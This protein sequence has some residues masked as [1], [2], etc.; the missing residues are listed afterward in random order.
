MSRVVDVFKSPTPDEIF[1]SW[2]NSLSDSKIR[3]Y[4]IEKGTRI[5]RSRISPAENID[6]VEKIIFGLIFF[7]LKVSPKYEEKTIKISNIKRIE[8]YDY[9]TITPVPIFSS[10]KQIPCKSCSGSGFKTCKHCDGLG[11]IKCTACKGT[12]KLNCPDCDGHGKI[13]ITVKVRVNKEKT[14]KRK[15]PVACPRCHGSGKIL[16]KDCSG[17]GYNPCSRCNGSGK[18]DCK[19]CDGYGSLIKYR[20]GPTVLGD[21]TVRYISP[22][23]LIKSKELRESLSFLKEIE[24]IKL[25]SIDDIIEEK[26]IKI[27][28]FEPKNYDEFRNDLKR[29]IDK[30]KAKAQNISYNIIVYPIIKI[31][32]K[33]VKNKKALIIGIGS[34]NRYK[35][36]QIQ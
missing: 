18:V 25:R 13:D 26:L 23:S 11:K 27:L 22:K 7:K 14:E 15:I 21:R 24:G 16:C 30:I 6:H 19:D 29:I 28:G 17:F 3:Q 1:I 35:V 8:F 31:Y 32:V 33:T 34:A 9:D 10:I 2:I 12:G 4:F 36:I 20:R 5:D